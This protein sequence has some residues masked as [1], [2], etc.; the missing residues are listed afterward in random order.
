MCS[1]GASVGV[2]VGVVCWSGVLVCVLVWCVGVCVG[3]VCWC[4][5]WCGALVWCWCGVWVW[6]VCLKSTAITSHISL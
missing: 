6:C 1:T 3:V 2:C 4:V 5:C